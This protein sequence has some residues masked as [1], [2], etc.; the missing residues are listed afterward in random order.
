MEGGVAQAFRRGIVAA[1]VL[2]LLPLGHTELFAQHASPLPQGWSQNN[3]Y[4]QQNLPDQ[5]SGYGQAQ[6]NYGHAQAPVQPLDMGRLEQLIAPIALYPDT[7]VALVLAASTY[8]TQV[9]D[10]D[11]WRQAQGDASPFDIAGGADVQNWDPSVKALT[12]FPQVLEEMDRNLR[13]TTDLGNAY[14]NQ[15]QDLLAAVQAMRQ[16]AQAAGNLQS[17]PQQDVRYDQGNIEVAPANP[18]VVYVP[19]YNPWSVYGQSVAPYQGFSLFGALQSVLGSSFGS[20]GSSPVGF[21]LGTLMTAFSHTSWGWLG[22]GLNWLSQAVLFNHSDYASNSTTVADWGLPHGGARAYPAQAAFAGQS[23]GGQS[24][25]SRWPPGRYGIDATPV[26][27]FARTQ[28]RYAA[29][30]PSDGRYDQSRTTAYGRPGPEAYNRAPAPIVRQQQIARPTYSTG[31]YNHSA[32]GY[33]SAPGYGNGRSFEAYRAPQTNF[34]RGEVGNRAYGSSSS[35]YAGKAQKPEKSG[36]FHLFGGGN[37]PK[38]NQPKFSEPK[39]RE[40][41]QPKFKQPKS[42]SGHSSSGGHSSGH[43]SGKHHH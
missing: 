43:S 29:N 40:A 35:A 41:K 9:V 28:D 15:P 36:G 14:Y 8:P 20:S 17:T 38:F 18:Q 30:R 4:S 42:S 3:S 25:G 32:A 2:L 7:L 24:N 11:R 21:G 39:Y 33:N 16:R 6:A 10:A 27:G 19:A 22:W 5:Q 37:Q 13:W 34:Q 1:I 23:M 12:A 26:Q 31:F